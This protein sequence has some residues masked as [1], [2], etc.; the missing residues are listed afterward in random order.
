MTMEKIHNDVQDWIATLNLNHWIIEQQL[1]GL[2]HDDSLLKLPFRANRLN[3]VVGHIAE[4]RDWMLRAVDGEPLM[5]AKQALLYRRGSDPITDEDAMP[6]ATLVTHL[7]TAKGAL[8]AKLEQVDA[9]FLAEKPQE[10][11][12]LEGHRDRTR[13]QRLQGLLWHE[14]YHVGQLELLRQATGANDKII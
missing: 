13:L 14:T 10:G 1:N 2:D 9:D 12:L 5:T 6:L 4:H 11:L 8:I 7:N 3:W